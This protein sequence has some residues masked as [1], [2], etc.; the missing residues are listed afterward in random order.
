[1]NYIE[2]VGRRLSELLKQAHFT[3]TKFAKDSKTS[4]VTVNTTI[5]GKVKSVSFEMLILFCKTLNITLREFF[6]S[7]L[8]NDDIELSEKKKGM[9]IN[10]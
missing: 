3:Q 9:R 2:A 1:M 7:D 5:N 8:F 4:R 10:S 6:N